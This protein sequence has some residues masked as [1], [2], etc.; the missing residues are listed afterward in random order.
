MAKSKVWKAV[1]TP[2]DGWP[3]CVHCGVQRPLITHAPNCML[4]AIDK[5]IGPF[6]VQQQVAIATHLSRYAHQLVTVHNDGRDNF[7]GALRYNKRVT[8]VVRP[9]EPKCWTTQEERSRFGDNCERL[10][11]EKWPH[12]STKVKVWEHNRW[13]PISTAPQGGFPILHVRGRSLKGRIYDRMHFARDLSGDE[14]PPFEGWFD[15]ATYNQVDPFEWQ[16][17]D[18]GSD[19][20]QL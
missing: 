18:I 4:R 20:D 19:R 10:H 9:P 13:D 7:H 3:K 16:P 6:H 14:Q 17:I 1:D 8:F 12:W 2:T 11:S 15:S 5:E